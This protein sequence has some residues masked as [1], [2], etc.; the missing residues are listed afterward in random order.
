MRLT[1]ITI[2]ALYLEVPEDMTATF[3]TTSDDGV[4]LWVQDHSL[5]DQWH[6][7]AATT[8]ANNL[9]LAGDVPVKIEYYEQ[10]GLASAHLVWS[11]VTD[12]PPPPDPPPSGTVLVDDKDA[13]FVRGGSSRTWNNDEVRANYNWGRWYPDLAGQQYEVFVYIPERYSTTQNARYW[14][15]HRGGYTLRQVDQSANSGRWV[16]LG[17]Y[18]F[19]GDDR[20]YVS[21]S[22]V[23]FESYV[24]R[25]IAFDA[26]RWEPR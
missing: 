12:Y 5:I 8:H 1:S 15:S 20:D 25:L 21:L 17:T 26:V 2:G 23:T 6:Q 13:G 7:Q 3:T 11:R 9:Y 18:W 24:S 4:R 16:S 14:V 22:D 19:R 10:A